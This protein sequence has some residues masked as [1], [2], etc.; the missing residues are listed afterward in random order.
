MVEN[1]RTLGQEYVG[2]AY[3][4]SENPDD[5]RRLAQTSQVG[6][7]HLRNVRF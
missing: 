2:S 3:Y 7:D 1:F 5:R 4:R 6:F